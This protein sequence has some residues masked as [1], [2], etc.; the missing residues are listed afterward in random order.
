[1]PQLQYC[2]G[3][4]SRAPRLLVALATAIGHLEPRVGRGS[5][6]R[7]RVTRNELC[8]SGGGAGTQQLAGMEVGVGWSR[9]LREK[10]PPTLL[11]PQDS[12]ITASVSNSIYKHW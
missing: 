12:P 4:A 7:R 9:G 6:P 2:G 5:G 8:G 1:M 3:G 10:F 11:H